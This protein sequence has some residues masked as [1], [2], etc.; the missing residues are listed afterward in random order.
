MVASEKLPEELH[1]LISHNTKAHHA[2]DCLS[3]GS[4]RMI[5]EKVAA[6]KLPNTRNRR[7]SLALGIR[8]PNLHG[9]MKPP[10]GLIVSTRIITTTLPP[11]AQGLTSS[12]SSCAAPNCP[13]GPATDAPAHCARS[14]SALPLPCAIF[15]RAQLCPA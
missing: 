7:A 15:S 11:R 8:P 1:E 5:R 2:W 9:Q 13:R 10:I 14:V 4:Q 3:P 6:A 12:Q